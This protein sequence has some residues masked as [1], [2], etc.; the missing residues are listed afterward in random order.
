MTVEERASELA[1]EIWET[2]YKDDMPDA[3][4]DAVGTLMDEYP[5]FSEDELELLMDE[6]FEAAV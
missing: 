3:L 1:T 6:K 4:N 2:V 5:E